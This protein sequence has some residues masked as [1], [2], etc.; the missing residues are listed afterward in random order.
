MIIVIGIDIVLIKSQCFKSNHIRIRIV[1]IKLER[2]LLTC[3]SAL[4]DSSP[5][6][7]FSTTNTCKN[8]VERYRRIGSVPKVPGEEVQAATLNIDN[9][10]SCDE[11]FEIKGHIWT[12]C[13]CKFGRKCTKSMC[14]FQLKR[15]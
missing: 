3:L 7:K 9:N 15:M 8:S 12:L 2:E 14:I 1:K 13:M 5:C 10:I 6:V 4:E 11:I